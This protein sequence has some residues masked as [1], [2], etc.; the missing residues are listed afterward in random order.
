MKDSLR[1]C[2]VGA[3]SSYT[4]ELIEGI[5]AHAHDDL[6][7]DQ[8]NLSDIDA[9][10]LNIM[11]GLA[12]RTFR[13]SGR[14][15]LVRSDTRL[16]PMLE[17]ADFVI[18]QIRVG[19]MEARHLDESIPLKYG[20]L[21]QETTGPGG[22]CKALRTIPVILEIAR[23]VARIAPDAF[24][25]NYTNP[26]GILT[27][28]V[29]QYT[30]ARFIGLCSGIPGMQ[31]R[32]GEELRSSYPDLKSYSVGLNHLGFLYRFT[33][34]GRDVT[35]EA[36]RRLCEARPNEARLIE[37]LG[38]VPMSYLNYY[39]HRAKTVKKQAEGETRAQVVTRLQEEILRQAGDPSFVGKPDALRKR[40]GGGYS[41]ITF[42]VLRA[43]L[44][45]TGEEL[46]MSV[47]NRGTVDGIP[48]D[49]SVEVSCRVGKEG[50]Q[51]IRVGPIPASFRGLVQAVKA[52]ESLTV[53]AA[54]QRSRRLAL[55]ALLS[56]PL[57][58][59]MDIAEPLLSELIS[60]HK[61][62]LS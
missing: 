22:M 61:L 30:P 8:L 17:R 26:S 20:I 31:K 27:E 7:V 2:I 12:E 23:A 60:A 45:D 38:A 50:P 43:I 5:L 55:Q 21:G 48:A 47:P 46:V 25:L 37:T 19:G 28:A 44:R 59:D 57:V 58:G 24:I 33:S 34:N 53:E 42:D 49:A 40:G 41:S 36:I 35:R 56:H 3:G 52:Y 10:R 13:Q 18:A 39:F 15:I 1:L 16:E 54:M 6:P 14:K 32:L 29:T 51:P 11:A 62:D 9:R 4:P